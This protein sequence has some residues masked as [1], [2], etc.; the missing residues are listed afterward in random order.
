MSLNIE[1]FKDLSKKPESGTEKLEEATLKV[2]NFT[3]KID[4]NAAAEKAGIKIRKVNDANPGADIIMSGDEKAL[5]SYARKYLGAE[6]DSLSK[7]QP[8]LMGG[9]GSVFKGKGSKA[10]SKDERE[11]RD[12]Q[13]AMFQKHEKA[14]T[15]HGHHAVKHRQENSGYD[16]SQETK[17]K[18]KSMSPEHK[19][20]H[21]K[22]EAAHSAAEKAHDE[23][24][25]AADKVKENPDAYKKALEKANKASALA[26]Q[27]SKET[28]WEITEPRDQPS[29]D[30][31]ES[32]LT[33]INNK[34]EEYVVEGSCS[35]K[36]KLHANYKESSEYQEFFSKALEKFGVSSPDELDD[37]KKKEFFDYVDSNWNA[38]KESD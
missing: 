25:R 38:D 20:A 2:S 27:L 24:R 9:P 12:K 32:M 3:G 35:S 34:I 18:I 22:A 1:Y 30:L 14:S 33:R 29:I 19:N 28:K 6:G 17:D 5:V 31:P 13:I 37:E 36:K 7:I 21:K 8:D 10:P 15:A 23:A 4:R 16:F 26:K 11:Q